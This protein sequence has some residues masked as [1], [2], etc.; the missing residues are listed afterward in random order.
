MNYFIFLEK[1]YM[2]IGHLKSKHWLHLYVTPQK[3]NICV[4]QTFKKK[5]LLIKKE[6]VYIH[7]YISGY[8]LKTCE[9]MA[10][11]QSPMVKS[12]LDTGVD[13]N[14]VKQ[15]IERRL[16]KKGNGGWGTQILN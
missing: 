7:I 9:V 13:R 16:K 12:I 4:Q 1:C 2:S 6:R 10:E 5:W 14:I 11:M 8:E 3:K 15:V